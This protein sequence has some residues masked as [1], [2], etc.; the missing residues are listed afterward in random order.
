MHQT[1]TGDHYRRTSNQGSCQT[2]AREALMGATALAA[3]AIATPVM[4]QDAP[5][6]PAAA[7]PATAPVAPAAPAADNQD[8]EI[9]VT[10]SRV[11]RTGFNAPTPTTVLNAA[12]VQRRAPNNVSEVLNELPTFRA[13]IS[14]NTQ[15]LSI[16]LSGQTYLDL[17]G[18]G[19]QR[20]L[21]LLDGRRVTPSS[22]AGQVDVNVIPSSLI[23]NIDVVTGGASASWGSDAVA[24]VVNIILKKKLQGIEASAQYGI[25]NRGDDKNYT[26]SAA[27]GTGF[28][29][30]R[31]HI[32][33]GGE[34]SKDEGIGY[35]GIQKRQDWIKNR[36]S[37]TNANCATN[38]LPC[39]I[40]AEN[41]Q[42][43]N[44]APGGLI[45]GPNNA[46][47]NASGLL[48]TIFNADG[49]T[50]KLQYGQVFGSSMI[51]GSQPG[52]NF[53]VYQPYRAPV[54]RWNVLARLDFA[55]TDSLNFN[56]EGSVARSTTDFL[57]LP[58]KDGG[59]SAAA[60]PA[61]T[62]A[63]LLIARIDNPFLPASVR[64]AMQNAGLTAVFVGR[65]GY[66]LNGTIENLE[67]IRSSNLNQR[68]A[69]GLNGSLG[70]G[71]WKWDVY[72]QYGRDTV[73]ESRSG[74]NRIMA[75]YRQASDV[76][77]N[78]ANGQPICR[79][80]LTNP[81]NG[82]VPFNIF[83]VGSPS[84]AA[85][86]YTTGVGTLNSKY[87]QQ[88]AAAN[89]KGDLFNL[90]A[91]PISAALGAEWRKESVRQ[92]VDAT[93]AAGGFEFTNQQPLSG[94]FNVKEVYGEL[95][96]PI[97]K[98]SPMGRELDVQLAGRYTDYSTSGSVET[99]KAGLT[100]DLNSQ[101]RIR[102]AVS[103]DIRAGNMSELFTNQA[104]TPFVAIDRVLNVPSP[105]TAISS[106]AG[107]N[108]N[109]KPERGTT[110][111]AGVVLQPE[112]L[113]G[114]RFSVDY[115]NITING[116]ITRVD[117]QTIIDRCALGLAVY[118]GQIDR[119]PDPAN[120]YIT[121]VRSPFLN[122][123]KFQ[124]NGV[125]FELVYAR[126]TAFLPWGGN[127]VLRALATYTN[128][129]ATTDALGTVDRAG[130]L[131]GA[132]VPHWMGSAT[133]TYNLGG[134][135]T[136]IQGRFIEGGNIDNLAI[137]GTRT[138]ANI[139]TVPTKTIWS[140]SASYDVVHSG[141][142]KVQIFGIINNLFDSN[143][144]FPFQPSSAIV[145]PYY[146]GIGRAFRFGIRIKR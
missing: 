56:V 40:Y 113:P 125:D 118:C 67:H 134:F 127:F 3:L 14:P 110:Y 92:V 111:T 131:G 60:V 21:V 22:T 52:N 81:A 122:L 63:G 129:F 112:W 61:G 79:S 76:V 13:S 29:G 51:G 119:N 69:V 75:K 138:S 115:Y 37:V 94:G 30:D 109:L 145:S 68:I 66:N 72:Y 42:F 137:P 44:Q 16:T 117:G 33:I 73:D 96:V 39:T 43:S 19:S 70:V 91:G 139:Y 106:V 128:E 82:C 120:A 114:F 58:P 34:Y 27:A 142:Q 88:V 100:W 20:T 26:F 25:S 18:L 135:S 103:R 132:G 121:Q 38:G 11:N 59:S 4:A 85:I 133:L 48:G 35:A 46:A 104:A 98:D 32:L 7:A 86:A 31:G 15:S 146:D 17:R 93:S 9:V 55:L 23:E 80:T 12:E 28:L 143:P 126:P 89:L 140:L 95:V 130:Q 45:T 90:P 71:N 108:P 99:W 141:K 87:E 74:N 83:G 84:A 78:P 101:M 53:T 107:G 2:R 1:S 24:G 77:T 8:K 49:T 102:G 10:A 144:P 41:V 50:S 97:L 136:A 64:T 54:E 57:A 6:A 5:A 62:P 116:V 105:L 65:D 36:G 124:T 47:F 123:N